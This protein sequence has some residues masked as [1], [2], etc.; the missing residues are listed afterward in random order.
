[1]NGLDPEK[2]G[3][4]TAQATYQA[5]ARD[6]ASEEDRMRIIDG[7]LTNLAAFSGV[8]IAISGSVGGSVLAGGKLALGFAIAL[9]ATIA[10]AAT[11]LLCG[12]VTAFRG[13]S[14]KAYEGI[15]EPSAEARVEQ[16]SLERTADEAWARFASTLVVH[17]VSARQANDAKA[18]ATTR[19][20]WLVGA[21]FAI[22]VLA[23][24]VTAVGSVV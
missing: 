1:M 16:G 14:P 18:D 20:F 5:C 9:G 8:S 17:L 2:W 7:K 19:A 3:A 11:L 15:D 21:G 13:L 4:G 23:I 6:L 24:V 10:V 22:L 12:V